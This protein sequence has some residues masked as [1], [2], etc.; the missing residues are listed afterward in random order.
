MIML[1]LGLVELMFLLL[2]NDLWDLI[3]FLC[4][5]GCYVLISVE[6]IVI[7]LC[8]MWCEYC[9]VGDMFMMC[10]VLVLLLFLMLKWLDEVEYL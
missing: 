4:I 7:Y 5:Y 2:I 6:M 1:N 9:V 3:G 8:N 10:E